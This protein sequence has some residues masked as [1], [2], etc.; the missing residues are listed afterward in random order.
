MRRSCVFPTGLSAAL[1]GAAGVTV[2]AWAMLGDWPEV[3]KRPPIGPNQTRFLRIGVVGV[4]V[5]AAL[6]CGSSP[7]T[8]STANASTG[9]NGSGAGGA[10]ASAYTGY[11][12][13][14]RQGESYDCGVAPS[15]SAVTGGT[16]YR[17]E[18]G[19]SGAGET[20]LNQFDCQ[21]VGN[22]SSTPTV[23]RQDASGNWVIS[24]VL[25][26]WTTSPPCYYKTAS[27]GLSTTATGLS[28]KYSDLR[29]ALTSSDGATCPKVKTST[30]ECIRILVTEL[31]RVN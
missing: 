25:D 15:L 30:L 1:I 13:E 20:V 11:F 9:G 29:G 4:A 28:N 12:R 27:Y 31:D 22:C 8:D 7:T 5:Y 23:F 21:A 24:D 16:L 6:A 26:Q 2:L 17:L 3:L 14:A 18:F 19:T 10:T